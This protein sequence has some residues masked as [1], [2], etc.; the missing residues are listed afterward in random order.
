[1]A[2]SRRGDAHVVVNK[3]PA[4][5]AITCGFLAL[6][7]ASMILR[8]YVRRVLTRS[9]GLDD[10]FMVLALVRNCSSVNTRIN[11][12]NIHSSFSQH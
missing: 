8:V 3:G 9:F 6:T 11:F 5:E 4:L 1:M 12:D 7:W 10:W 2:F